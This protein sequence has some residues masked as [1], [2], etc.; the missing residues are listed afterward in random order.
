MGITKG[1]DRKS[2]HERG[3][4][5]VVDSWRKNQRQSI[6]HRTLLH[7]DEYQSMFMPIVRIKMPVFI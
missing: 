3:E 1:N 4:K 7:G 5:I 6:G 2:R